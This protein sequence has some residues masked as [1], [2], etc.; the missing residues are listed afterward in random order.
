MKRSTLLKMAFAFTAMF[1]F[2]GAFAQVADD[3]T[4]TQLTEVTMYQ[5]QGTNFMVY[6]QPDPVYSPS[7]NHNDQTGINTDSYWNFTLTGGLTL[8][9]PGSIIGPVNQNWVEVTATT[10]GAQTITVTEQFGASGCVSS[11][12][13]SQAVNV[14]AAPSALIST[15]D[16]AVRCATVPLAP[17]AVTIA[18]T[19]DVLATLANYAF[20]VTESVDN[21][22]DLSGTNSTNV[23]SNSTFVDHPTTAKVAAAGAQPNYTV[24]FNTSALSVQNSKITVYTYTLVRASNLTAGVSGIVSTVS[25]K[26]D[27]L[28]V[29]GGGNITTYAW[30]GKSTYQAIVA[31]APTTGPIYHIP[32]SYNAF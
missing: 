31:P 32:N 26:S 24:T 5:T 16:P 10:P 21:W 22:D 18:I 29:A 11:T 8:V 20:T 4:A 3:Y 28:T 19:E 23:S 1:M 6:V 2:S 27:Y 30:A 17:D 9:Q 25:H 13:I 15:A 12:V 14:V 7:Y